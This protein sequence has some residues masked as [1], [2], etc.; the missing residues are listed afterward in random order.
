MGIPLGLVYI[1]VW[2]NVLDNSLVE[3]V[4]WVVAGALLLILAYINCIIETFFLTY[5]YQA[6]QAISKKE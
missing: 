3:V 6:Y 5:W 2:L 1:A 4:I